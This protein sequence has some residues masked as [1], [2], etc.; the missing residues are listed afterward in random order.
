MKQQPEKVTMSEEEFCKRIGIARVTAWRARKEGK[1]PFCRVGRSVV[2]L[3][4]HIEEF[5]N[6]CERNGSKDA[7]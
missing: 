2:Y 3:E 5:L 7:A 6:A 4:R 1:L